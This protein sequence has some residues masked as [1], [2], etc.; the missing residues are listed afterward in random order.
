MGARTRPAAIRLR[1]CRQPQPGELPA[2][3]GMEEVAI[4]GTDV[5]DGGGAGAA[6]QHELVAHELAVVL[7][8]RPRQ[9]L[10]AGIRG[11]SAAR[12]LPDVAV[13]LQERLVSAGGA[14]VA[15]PALDE[16][17]LYRRALARNLPLS[18]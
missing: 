5:S 9:R 1:V 11:V 15:A 6:A 17:P 13:E 4:G 14:R 3:V 16:V 8:Q 7:A 2:A 18:F 12:P 10:E